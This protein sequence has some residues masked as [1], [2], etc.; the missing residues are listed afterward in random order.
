[1]GSLP[2]ATGKDKRL[3]R[4]KPQPTCVSSPSPSCPWWRPLATAMRQG[5]LTWSSATRMNQIQCVGSNNSYH[6]QPSPEELVTIEQFIPGSSRDLKYSQAA[7][8]IQLN[9]QSIRSLELDVFAD[10]KG[11]HYAKPLIRKLANLP[12][13]QDPR[14]RERGTK[15]LHIA[16]GDVHTT[17]VT[18]KHCLEL[19]KS[20]SDAHRA[21]IPLPILIEFNESD[22]GL[23]LLGGAKAIPWNDEKLLAGLDAEIR[24]IFPADRLIVPDD[25][26]RG[27]PTNL[28]LEDA[29]LERG[30]PDLDSAR[31]RVFFLMDN[32]P[33]DADCA[34][35]KLNNP[36]GAANTAAIQRAVQLNYW[37]RTRAD[38]PL[39]TLFSN[40]T[41]GM[42][43]AA[44][45]S[46]AQVVSTDFQQYGMSSPSGV[47]YAVRLEGGR[48]ARCNPV[49]GHQ[50]V[51][52]KLE[53][54]SPQY[55]RRQKARCEQYVP[56]RL[57]ANVLWPVIGIFKSP[58]ALTSYLCRR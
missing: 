36:T 27:V 8:D 12:Y 13:D 20:W 54:E 26:R 45:A 24:A 51:V 41:T 18:L 56:K 10:P 1:M 57:H 31:G 47:D 25:L 38:V 14:W 52:D 53:P 58:S 42:R 32:G 28:T 55:E 37:V 33:G 34:F 21:H 44:L 23:V 7:L 19:V 40:D 46:G 29:V 50:C 15:V 17:C 49:V 9:Y 30:W 5:G 35:R 22:P 2:Y 16:D 3:S 11:G 6:L 48:A 4:T 43:D 39:E